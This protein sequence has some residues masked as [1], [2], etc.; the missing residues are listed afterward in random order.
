MSELYWITRLDAICIALGLTIFMLL[1]A[2]AFFAMQYYDLREDY[3]RN[4]TKKDVTSEIQNIVKRIGKIVLVVV[5]L[6]IFE[7]F[8]PTTKQAL[9]IYG[10]GGTIDY[11]KSNDTANQ[12]PDK[13]ISA[14][15]K[16]LDTLNEE[17]DEKDK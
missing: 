2:I 8:I 3:I 1:L 15:D 7:V 12:L 16:Y 10:I 14:L 9:V 13:V 11:I 4:Y 6:V 5:I 17:N